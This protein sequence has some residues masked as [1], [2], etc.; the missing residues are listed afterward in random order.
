MDNKRKYNKELKG[1]RTLLSDN[2]YT[3]TLS[4][5]YHQFL[6]DMH[7]KLIGNN[8]VTNKMLEAINVA[9]KYYDNYSKPKVKAQR[10][11]MLMKITKLKVMLT[12]CGYTSQY[13][14]EKMEFL[15]SLTNRAHSRGTLTPKQAKYANQMYK[16]FNKKIMPKSA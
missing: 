12:Q 9:S 13:E 6:A 2:E 10:E 8:P 1:L 11:S 5:G 16:Q 3:R 14:A 15:D 4:S 7:R